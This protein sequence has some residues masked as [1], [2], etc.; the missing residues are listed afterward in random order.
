MLQQNRQALVV[1]GGGMR[2]AF[3]SGVL[4]AF[5]Q[6]QFN[7]F[8]LCV[9]VSSGSTNLANYL[10]AQQGRTLQIYL[11][12]S[13]RSEFIQYGRFFKG[14]DLLDL[15]WMWDVVE[16]EHPLNQSHLFANHPEFY[17]VLTHAISG[18]AT[19]IKASKDNILEG[20][21]ASSSIPVLTRQA[22]EVFGEPYFDGGVADALPIHWAAQQNNV[23]KLMVLRTRPKSYFKASSKGDQFLAKYMFKQQRGFAQS[24]LARTQ[25]YNDSVEFVRSTSQPKILEVCPPD[26][27]NM[28]GRLSKNKAKIRYSYDVGIETGLKAIEQWKLL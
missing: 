28:A 15:K 14:G 12:H 27:K 2:G 20:L 13:L 9:G 7:P 17:M 4:D 8:D 5:L 11:D 23:S 1:E 18:E 24:L 22:V 21:R 16:K 10:A 3:T 19:Y 25:R 6:Q 26:L